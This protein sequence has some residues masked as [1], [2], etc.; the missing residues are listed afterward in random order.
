MG[1]RWR[2]EK[3]GQQKS[4]RRKQ[5]QGSGSAGAAGGTMGGLRRGFRSLLGTGGGSGPKTGGQKLFDGLLWVAVIVAVL[6]FA[7]KRCG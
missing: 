1:K 4:R 7:A 6:V 2:K 5:P 3:A